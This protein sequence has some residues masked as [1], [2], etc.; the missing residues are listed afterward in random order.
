MELVH[1][2]STYDTQGLFILIVGFGAV[3]M[4]IIMFSFIAENWKHLVVFGLVITA[5]YVGAVIK[6]YTEP[7][8]QK[9]SEAYT[10]IKRSK[11]AKM[12]INN[13]PSSTSL[14]KTKKLML[15]VIMENHTKSLRKRRQNETQL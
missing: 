6:F 3:I 14:M 4:S 13:Q 12:K 7:R 10:I 2:L 1:Q 8:P 11:K 5:L 15:Y 9:F